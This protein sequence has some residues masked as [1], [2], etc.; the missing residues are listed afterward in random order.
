M[1]N[2]DLPAFGCTL[3]ILTQLP[4]CFFEELSDS[5]EPTCGPYALTPSRPHGRA[6]LPA[7]VR[8]RE[9]VRA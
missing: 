7:E 3:P 9:G 6:L 4:F 2:T 5:H 1:N 8:T